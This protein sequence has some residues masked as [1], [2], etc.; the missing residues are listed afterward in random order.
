MS[1][2]ERCPRLVRGVFAATSLFLAAACGSPSSVDDGASMHSASDD[3]R[4]ETDNV[5]GDDVT[6][7]GGGKPSS[8]SDLAAPPTGPLPYRGVNLAGAEFGDPVPGVDGEDYQ[9]PNTAE[10]DY[11]IGK[12]MNTFR[13]GFKW[14]RLQSS[15][16]DDLIAA[17]LKQLDALVAHATSKHATVILNPHNFARYYGETVGSANVPNEVFA[18]LWKRL[19]ARY[20]RNPY[21]MF[22]L[23]NEPNTM[24]T[25]QWV[26]AANA[27]IAAIRRTNARNTIIV[28]GNAWTGAYS[29]HSSSYGTPNAVAMLDIVDP[30]NNTV[31]EVHQYLDEKAG[32]GSGPCVSGTIGSE[33]LAGFVEWL[34]AHGK[35]GFVGELAGRDDATCHAAVEDMMRYMHASSDVLVGW[36]WWAA[37]PGWGD[38]PFS[39]EPKNG[40]DRALLAKIRP[41]LF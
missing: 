3:D 26:G 11:F 16:Y 9:F 29:W 34:R 12:G 2:L 24:P 31:F 33:R 10:M 28:P 18:D 27:A 21:I 32:G 35:K 39:I 36:L 4:V 38:Y 40:Q 17:Y 6:T 13:V 37:G 7:T 30:A 15:P 14:E 23:V 20:G 5:V 41:F 8:A 25:E 22:N 1:K 19:A